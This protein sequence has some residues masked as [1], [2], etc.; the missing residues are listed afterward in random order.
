MLAQTRIAD[1]YE[2][3]EL[4]GEGGMGLVFRAYDT[5]TRSH[6]AVKTMRDGSDP[7][8]VE[9]FTKEWSVLADM[10]HPNIV[11]IRDV[12][13]IDDGKQRRPFFVMPLLQG[14]TLAQLIQGSSARLTVERVVG[15]FSQACRGLQAA[16]EKGLVHRDL[17]PSNIFVMSDDSARIIDFGVVYLAGTNTISG[18]KG[19]W[20]YMAPEQAELKPATPAS[21][22][23]SLGVVAYE[24]LTGLKPFARK[25]PMETI[26]AVRTHIP[27]PIC[28]IN[29]NVSQL[30][31]KVIHKAMAKDPIHRFLSARDFSDT[32]QK[33]F[34]NQPIERFDPAK[35]QPR[36][37]RARKAFA[38]G[39][40][41]FASEI[42]TELG[43]EGHIDPETSLLRAQIAEAVKQKKIRQLLESART[44]MEQDEFP[45][46]LD[47]LREVLDLDGANADA[48]ALRGSIEMKRSER[49]I[50]KWMALARQH[51]DVRDFTE[52]RQAL[53]EV[54]GLTPDYPP[55]IQMLTEL[56]TREQTAIRI[57]SEKEQLCSVAIKAYQN[58]EISNALSKLERILSLARQTPDAA[59]PDRDAVYQS[60]YNQVRSD[61]DCIRNGYEDG[62]RQLAEKNFVKALEI[63]DQLL[64][65][66]PNDA[67]LQALRLE[68]VEAQRQDLSAYIAEVGKRV[69]AEA[70]LER[71]VNIVKEACVRYPN[72]QQFQQSLKLARD[73]RDLIQSILN[74][75][76][77]Y[78]ENSQLAEA[79]G[80]WDI[81][82]NIHP[83]FPGLEFEI[84]Q[85]V[86][87]R[88]QQ[89]HEDD[90][91]RLI[92]QIDRELEAG[93]F[94]KAREL[95]LDAL[96]EYP[97]HQELAGLE[98]LARQGLE[99]SEEAQRLLQEAKQAC[100]SGDF[101][102]GIELLNS[103]LDLSVH[104]KIAR[105]T[106]MSVLVQQARAVI[107]AD[108][109]KAETYVNRAAELDDKHPAVRGLRSMIADAK[110]KEHV[111][112]CLAEAR[113]LQA[114]TGP[115]AAL[116][117]VEAGLAP[118]PAEPRL[119][120]YR[121]TL[122]N[123][124]PE[125][126]KQQQKTAVPAA[127]PAAVAP[128]AP[129]PPAP[130]PQEFTSLL[131]EPEFAPRQAAPPVVPAAVAPPP[132]PKSPTS[133]AAPEEFTSLVPG[134]D[135]GPVAAPPAAPAAKTPQGKAAAPA[136][137]APKPP[138][139]PAAKKPKAAAPATKAA[140][141]FRFPRRVS[142][143]VA[144]GLLVCIGVVAGLRYGVFSKKP[145]PPAVP[146]TTIQ[147]RTE[148]ADAVVLVDGKPIQGGRIE[149][150]LDQPHS[151]SV[152]R[153]GYAAMTQTGLTQGS[154][155]SFTLVPEPLHIRVSTGLAAGQ[156]LI[157]GKVVGNLDQGD[158]A[159]Y[160]LALDGHPHKLAIRSAAGEAFAID[161][162]ATAG[163]RPSVQ[164]V[165]T[166][167]VVVATSLA[168]EATLYT[169][170]Q[171]QSAGA[172]G[173]PAQAVPR[174]GLTL[175]GFDAQNH[176]VVLGGSIT[177]PV[178]T[179]NAPV[180]YAAFQGNPNIGYAILSTD[181]PG[182]AIWL[183]GAAVKPAAPGHW[184]VRK[185]AGT[186]KLKAVAPGYEELD[187]A[188]TIAKG[189]RLARKL[190]LK[191]T[192]VA[193]S[194]AISSGTGGAEVFLDG[195]QLGVVAPDGTFHYDTISPGQHQLELRRD[196]FES[197]SGQLAFTAGQQTALG[198]S[199]A[200]LR[201]FGLIEFRVTPPDA[202]KRYRK[203]DARDFLDVSGSASTR[204]APGAYEV[205]AGANGYVTQHQILTV[206]PGKA[207]LAEMHLDRVAAPAPAPRPRTTTELVDA[208]DHI[209]K[210]GDWFRVKKGIDWVDLKPGIT[211]LTLVL[212]RNGKDRKFH[213][214]RLVLSCAAGCRIMYDLDGRKI[215]RTAAVG[216]KQLQAVQALKMAANAAT[217]SINVRVQP[218][219]IVVT[220]ED[221][222][223]LD[224][225]PFD[226]VDLTTGRLAIGGES[227]FAIRSH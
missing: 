12:G 108:W 222:G 44:R 92:E 45:L 90:R 219:R 63:A 23:F 190:D 84:A 195:R 91:A 133:K 110:R 213:V 122:L 136:A 217:Y 2:L 97:E 119:L 128:V 34:L 94:A 187:L 147:V 30:V 98:R 139:P 124:L 79:L 143:E 58:G 68:V 32:L 7:Q 112:K 95:A 8:A 86:K 205:E 138:A 38:D 208:P 145:A 225:F 209:V 48:L 132:P 75:A 76:R 31:S 55:A 227:N 162:A 215:S 218:H 1:R 196:G 224:V 81:L 9:L 107:D 60:F 82:R 181:V 105:E 113:S 151:V 226:S 67:M 199:E 188:L 15:I 33:A 155:W 169:G 57:R 214:Q 203:T 20:Q 204:L 223:E 50:D 87:R 134:A 207:A 35:I 42:L 165:Q 59:L 179:G 211:D 173:R 175:S 89:A 178:D 183:D 117:R 62:R 182:V 13:E 212:A 170:S 180:L 51:L 72:E 137:K 56:D 85:L 36:I 152:S 46:A 52:A 120:Q 130:Q 96:K 156:A 61:H 144:A 116:E 43:A 54:L 77:Q 115:E 10:S 210:D 164:P 194:L 186:Y 64:A 40:Y 189:E 17:K 135:F 141:K 28:D 140:T 11:E 202:R 129:V 167:G 163:V 148:P 19:T 142:L 126:L 176:Q 29:P 201:E 109:P 114:E 216:P 47:K 73:R 88:E 153:P 70:D 177:I 104:D 5:K 53:R 154:N 71:R 150:A 160:E 161:F 166:P 78:E 21:D 172:V 80:Q 206:P 123:L 26:E 6:V 106:L 69:E 168:G 220:G 22:I 4:L 102:K 221:G 197:F 41:G 14:A 193:G 99:R 159:D 65:K 200:S 174:T 49:Q 121:G 100:S 25:T 39:D 171:G 103:A 185:D 101:D 192:P 131:P 93:A 66:F 146:M 16:H 158:L 125:K 149:T 127:P 24:A 198:G 74:R 83:Q 118:Y 27:P 157:D 18:H 37:D 3:K 191:S 184:L 111:A